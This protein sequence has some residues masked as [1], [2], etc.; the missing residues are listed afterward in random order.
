M[1]QVIHILSAL[2]VLLAG[3]R[4]VSKD[5]TQVMIAINSDFEAVDELKM[6]QVEIFAG[7]GSGEPVE[8]RQ[9]QLRRRGESAR[10]GTQEL[11]FSMSLI[12]SDHDPAQ[13]FRVVT[14]GYASNAAAAQAVVEQKVIAGFAKEQTLLL[15]VFLAKLC[16]GNLCDHDSTCY[17][18]YESRFKA[19]ECGTIPERE[20]TPIAP[21]QALSAARWPE[22]GSAVQIDGGEHEAGVEAGVDAGVQ[23]GP[24]GAARPPVQ[25]TGGI[26]DASCPAL[27]PPDSSLCATPDPWADAGP[28]LPLP[29]K[30]GCAVF[31]SSLRQTSSRKLSFITPA[32]N[33][34]ARVELSY[35]AG[36]DSDYKLYA[37]PAGGGLINGQSSR[38]GL[39]ETETVLYNATKDR[40]IELE[41]IKQSGTTPSCQ[42]FA[43]RVDTTF[44]T[45]AFEDNDSKDKPTQVVWDDTGRVSYHLS[46][47]P[48]DEDHF[49]VQATR[50]DPILFTGSYEVAGGA[51]TDLTLWITNLTGGSLAGAQATRTSARETWRLWVM[52]PSAGGLL[53]SEV[54]AA[55]DASCVEYDL[56]IDQDACTDAR[57][58]DDEASARKPIVSGTTQYLTTFAKDDDHFDL[59]ALKSGTCVVSY[60]PQRGDNEQKIVGYLYTSSG[61]TGPASSTRGD[62]EKTLTFRWQTADQVVRLALSS[63]ERVCQPYTIRCDP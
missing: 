58:D 24:D 45:D 48:G 26:V 16:E 38:V 35:A 46:S 11:P 47:F 31:E 30:S 17:L 63:S 5:A 19:G 51:N 21:D 20:L 28:V 15:E 13:R 34:P 43:L 8:R 12:P 60:V 61:S 50:A 22:A 54:S 29:F 53:R 62:A 36:A 52:A 1:R 56:Q 25:V 32:M 41:V 3:C 10:P 57:E 39:V 44:C 18:S 37:T 40:A 4:P 33:E 49:L 42:P 55:G 9:F 14:T 27:A 6:I 2:G 23:D 59:S 7:D